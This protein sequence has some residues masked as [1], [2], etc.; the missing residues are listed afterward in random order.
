M[1]YNVYILCSYVEKKDLIKK[2][3]LL[4]TS[5]LIQEN[6]PEGVY[7]PLG[8]FTVC[9]LLKTK[10]DVQQLFLPHGKVM[11]DTSFELNL[12]WTSMS[13]V[14]VPTVQNQRFFLKQIAHFLAN[15]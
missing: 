2:S 14:P 8:P 13:Y 11:P 9:T 15:I 5:L 6:L 4:M 3:V 7:L 1:P 12:E 10:G